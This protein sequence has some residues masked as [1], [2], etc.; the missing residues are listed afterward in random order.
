MSKKTDEKK[1]SRETVATK[2]AEYEATR[3][4]IPGTSQRQLAEQLGVPRSTLQHWI[5]RR[6]SI[7]ADP[8]VIAFFESPAGV[9]FLHRLVIAAQFVITL[10]GVGGI[11]LVCT[12]LELSGLESFI[13]ASYGSQQKVTVSM[14]TA[15][16]A[17]GQAEQKRMVAGMNPKQIT[18][19]QDE[20]F[21]PEICLVAIEAVSNYILLEKYAPDRKAETWTAEMKVALDG[22]PIEVI[23]ST[24]DEGQGLCSHVKKHLCAHHSPDLFH[25]QREAVQA[26]SVVL[27]G[28]TRQAEKT[29][30]AAKQAVSQE[31][32]AQVA[33]VNGKRGRGRPPA[34]DRRIH[35]A[36]ADQQQE[37]QTAFETAQAHQTRAK[38]AVQAISATYH[39]YDLE[40]GAPRTA[41][42]VATA[43]EQHFVELETIA[44]EADLPERCFKK[45]KKA[46]KVGVDMVATIAFFWLT[47]TAKVETLGLAPEVERGV[48]DHLI[49]AIYLQQVAEKTANTDQRDQLHQKSQELLAPFLA[50]AG[51]LHDL[52]TN[53]RL[54][55]EKVAR[56]CAELFQRSSSCVEGRNGQLALRHH[57][58]H[59]ISDRKLVAL[60]TIHNYF[61]QR[62][63]G[64][65]AA[66]RFFAA[67]PNDLFVSLLDHVDLPGR[68]A[69]SRLQPALHTPLLQLAA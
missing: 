40:S 14:E 42:T 3:Q 69:Q 22:M 63:D 66:E 39:P 43:L 17:F 16:V 10:L 19:C 56:E 35:Q 12:F 44:T 28:K 52:T 49:P 24:S 1:H 67:K 68:P 30:A 6:E 7:D 41:E 62:Q 26:T 4:A 54:V 34:F 46:K 48:Y 13:A 60:K 58:L 53:E 57:S 8:E 45:I 2:L 23:Q 51:P 21:H 36:A 47:V 37:A 29:L 20:T 15:V 9:A 18:V 38:Q 50:R 5:A 25:V 27:A 31:R 65:T 11:R 33:Y 55:I 32:A 59:R 64:T 61:I